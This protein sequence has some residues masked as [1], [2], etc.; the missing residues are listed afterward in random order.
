VDTYSTAIA[1]PVC[2]GL[3]FPTGIRIYRPNMMKMGVNYWGIALIRE[4]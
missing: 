3:T 1:S 4:E 2:S